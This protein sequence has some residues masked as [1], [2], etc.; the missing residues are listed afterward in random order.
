MS[1]GDADG[2][3]FTLLDVNESSTRSVRALLDRSSLRAS[4]VRSDASTYLHERP[5]HVVIAETMQRSLAVEPH[6]AITRN[7]R[8]QLAPRGLFVPERI[9]VDVALVDPGAEQARWAGQAVDPLH[10]RLATVIDI[11]AEDERSEP[12]TVAF[13]RGG[14]W[15]ALLTEIDVFGRETLRQYDSGLTT[16]EILWSLSP[17]REGDLARFHY[18]VGSRPGI[19]ASSGIR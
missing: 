9:H 12:V 19:R 5:I 10:E 13:P 16:P 11:T 4:V 8:M 7:L 2:V 6:V 1:T 15:V 14:R 17:S 18:E 3:N